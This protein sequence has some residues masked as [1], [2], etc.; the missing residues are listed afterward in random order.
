MSII[1][2]QTYKL[3]VPLYKNSSSPGADVGNLKPAA[4]AAAAVVMMMMMMPVTTHPAGLEMFQQP[5][6]PA[7]AAHI[8]NACWLRQPAAAPAV[9]YLLAA[10]AALCQLDCLSA[11]QW[12]QYQ[13]QQKQPVML[14]AAILSQVWEAPGGNTSAI[15]LAGN[16]KGPHV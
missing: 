16:L 14:V 1:G 15:L 5:S 9:M 12:W 6:I 10:V 8:R 13:Q 2:S 3:P 11:Q 7:A 4:A